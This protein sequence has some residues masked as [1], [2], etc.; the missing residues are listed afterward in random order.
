M[1]RLVS[2]DRVHLANVSLCAG[3]WG[4]LQVMNN[5]VEVRKGA[6][7][8]RYSRNVASGHLWGPP[9]KECICKTL[10]SPGRLVLRHPCRKRIAVSSLHLICSKSIK[11]KS[12]VLQAVIRRRRRTVFMVSLSI[13]SDSV[14]PQ[15]SSLDKAS[16]A[17]QIVTKALGACWFNFP[18]M[19]LEGSS[20]SLIHWTKSRI[21]TRLSLREQDPVAICSLGN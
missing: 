16:S 4:A 19:Y 6:V 13:G 5:L 11:A 3:L 8:F 21:Y 9:G 12:E 15:C 2:A 17:S 18:L 14:G 7:L 10:L 1:P 20:E